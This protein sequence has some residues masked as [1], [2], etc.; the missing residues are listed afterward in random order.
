MCQ[1]NQR[2]GCSEDLLESYGMPK[3]PKSQKICH[4]LQKSQFLSG[5]KSKKFHI[6]RLVHYYM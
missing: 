1:Q 6:E 2:Y 3:L 5:N 4:I